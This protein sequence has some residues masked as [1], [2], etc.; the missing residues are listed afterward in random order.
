MRHILVA[1]AMM[2]MGLFVTFAM[3]SVLEQRGL[4]AVSA[5]FVLSR[6]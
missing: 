6:R 2:M 5:P 3:A 1:A 4:N